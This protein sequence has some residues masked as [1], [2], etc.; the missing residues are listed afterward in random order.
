MDQCAASK[1]LTVI[2][3]MPELEDMELPHTLIVVDPV[4]H[5]VHVRGHFENGMEA[6]R[7]AVEM[8]SELDGIQ[9]GEE[10]F[11]VIPVPIYPS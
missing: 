5:R 1:L 9:D 8:K 7:A 6:T 3:A 4:S 10:S 2:D 11:R